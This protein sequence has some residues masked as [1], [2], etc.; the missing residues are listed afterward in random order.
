M[1]NTVTISLNDKKIVALNM[2]LAQKNSSLEDEVSKFAE[3]LY[4]KI[5]PPNVRDFIEMT[6]K[7]QNEAKPKR[8]FT[9]LTDKP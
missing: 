4:G 6:S 7:Q 2:Y 8:T 3:Q 9:K 1:K 5:V